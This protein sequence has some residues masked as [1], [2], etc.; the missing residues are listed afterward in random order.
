[1]KSWLTSLALLAL[2]VLGMPGVAFAHSGHDESNVTVA[3]DDTDHG[4]AV[5][6]AGEPSG[7]DSVAHYFEKSKQSGNG[8]RCNGLCCCCQGMIRCGTSGSSL[9]ALLGTEA[10]P[11]FDVR[12][13][14]RMRLE[15]DAVSH[16]RR[17]FGLERPPKV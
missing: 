13:A 10:V 4:T 9:S 11:I 16:V 3:A 17:S 14:E 6:G 7:G 5:S 8:G 12:S 1:M 2:L 15:N